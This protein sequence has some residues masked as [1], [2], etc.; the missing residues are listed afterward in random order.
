MQILFEAQTKTEP[1][2][3]LLQVPLHMAFSQSS[4]PLAILYII[5]SVFILDILVTL[6]TS[7]FVGGSTYDPGS[8]YCSTMHGCISGW[9]FSLLS[10]LT[11]MTN[12]VQA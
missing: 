12:S 10:R 6:N 4:T 11:G 5:D 3:P 7:K 9:T 2:A 1:C 8:S